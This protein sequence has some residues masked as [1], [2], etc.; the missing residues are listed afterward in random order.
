MAFGG[1]TLK[2]FQRIKPGLEVFSSFGWYFWGGRS[3]YAGEVHV[4]LVSG[5]SCLR[6]P[7]GLGSITIDLLMFVGF[8]CFVMYGCLL[9][10]SLDEKQAATVRVCKS[11]GLQK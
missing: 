9:S 3:F 1:R 2:W 4:M 5:V 7:L 10:N 11:K 6:V 8:F